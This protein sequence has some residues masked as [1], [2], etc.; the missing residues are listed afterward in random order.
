ME[1]RN[2]HIGQDVG[3]GPD[4]VGYRIYLSV[5][6][7]H[8]HVQDAVVRLVEVERIELLHFGA[9][10][11]PVLRK[12][13][14]VAVLVRPQLLHRDVEDVVTVAAFLWDNLQGKPIEQFQVGRDLWQ[15][16]V[17]SLILIRIVDEVFK[18]SVTLNAKT[19]SV[20]N[21]PIGRYEL[22]LCRYD[23]VVLCRP[24]V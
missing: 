3:D 13:K 12:E 6:P 5:G 8:L 16:V 2:L 20:H 11:F 1:I 24:V 10:L 19:L 21:E 15:N 7:V 18:C 14:G 9:A 17:Q 23:G 4:V 22:R